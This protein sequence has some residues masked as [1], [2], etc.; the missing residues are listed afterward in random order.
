M[1]TTT[2]KSKPVTQTVHNNTALSIEQI[3]SRGLIGC[4]KNNWR[5]RNIR[6]YPGDEATKLYMIGVSFDGSAVVISHEDIG[7]N[8][9]V[10]L[11]YW[12]H[13]NKVS[14]SRSGSCREADMD[15]AISRGGRQI[16]RCCDQAAAG[17]EESLC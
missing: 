1:K 13:G 11:D 2:A 16:S 3:E 5:Q 9:G 17:V 14:R 15:R 4:I 10:A 12:K 8:E 6:L 7:M